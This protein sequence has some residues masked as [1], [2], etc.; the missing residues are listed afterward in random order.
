M[1]DLIFAGM[2]EIQLFCCRSNIS[3]G[4]LLA[5]EYVY[6]EWQMDW[7]KETYLER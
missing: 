3:V 4:E 7:T 1:P 2:T 6:L 5:G